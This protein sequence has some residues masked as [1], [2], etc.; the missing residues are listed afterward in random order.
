MVHVMQSKYPESS[1]D[2]INLGPAF[3]IN[4]R[5]VTKIE[6]VLAG[7]ETSWLIVTIANLD[8]ATSELESIAWCEATLEHFVQRNS[9][10][11]VVR[12]VCMTDA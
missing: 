1:E 12:T 7:Q 6:I 9:A 3:A 10:I 5:Y 11:E 2:K 8:D 4:P